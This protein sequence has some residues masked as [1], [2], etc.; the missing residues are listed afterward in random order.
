MT[1]TLKGGEKQ[2]LKLVL[3][4]FSLSTRKKR[5]ANKPWTL[6]NRFVF[7][8]GTTIAILILVY[9]HCRTEQ[10]GSTSMLLGTRETGTWKG[11]GEEEHC[12]VLIW[13]HHFLALP[14]ERVQRHGC[15]TEFS[16]SRNVLYMYYPV[17]QPLA[18]CGFWAWNVAGATE[19]RNFL[20]Y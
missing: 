9:V 8:N 6:F 10:Q 2:V 18:T 13:T 4:P 3:W 7:Q 12:G 11:A 16:E 20:F 1:I 15:S 17:R 19:E 5:T 14:T